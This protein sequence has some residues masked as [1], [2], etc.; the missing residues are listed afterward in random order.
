MGCHII[1]GNL[2]TFGI[3]LLRVPCSLQRGG[4]LIEVLGHSADIVVFQIGD[5]LNLAGLPLAE[6]HVFQAVIAQDA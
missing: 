6:E 2:Q 5:L 4:S 1:L 3:A